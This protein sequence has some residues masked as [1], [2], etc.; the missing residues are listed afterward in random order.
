VNTGF[1]VKMEF[2]R[3]PPGRPSRT[4]RYTYRRLGTPALKSRL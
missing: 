4:T 2:A 1:C 3:K